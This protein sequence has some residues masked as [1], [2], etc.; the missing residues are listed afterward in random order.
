MSFIYVSCYY[1]F[2]LFARSAQSAR[3]RN[4]VECHRL[5]NVT[6]LQWIHCQIYIDV[7]DV[8]FFPN[9]VFHLFFFFNVSLGATP[10]HATRSQPLLSLSLSLGHTVIWSNSEHIHA[11]RVLRIRSRS[12]HFFTV[13]NIKYLCRDSFYLFS[14][15]FAFYEYVDSRGQ[16]TLKMQF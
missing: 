16:L 6:L 7:D 2:C 12:E 15:R 14:F 10:H 9:T 5:Q 13:N 3:V 1:S 11:Q 8:I 4:R